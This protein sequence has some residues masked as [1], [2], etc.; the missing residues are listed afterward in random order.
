MK[1]LFPSA[2][3]LGFIFFG[4]TPDDN[5]TKTNTPALSKEIRHKNRLNFSIL[6]RI[7][8]NEAVGPYYLGATIC[9]SNN[10]GYKL[11]LQSDYN[12]VLYNN[13][14]NSALWASNTIGM[15][16]IQ[17]ADFRYDGEL[18]LAGGYT[19]WRANVPIASGSST[20]FR[21]V[22]Q[23]DGNFCRYTYN[24]NGEQLSA[25][26]STDTQGGRRSPHQGEIR[27]HF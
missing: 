21:W 5:I 15:N 13:Y 24:A 11:V 3:L 7:P 14:S 1:K 25:I 22:L 27:Y 2:I 10:G 20:S 23:D 9:V 19:F 4:F 12:L 26:A 6:N 18:Y 17:R 16:G 8:Q